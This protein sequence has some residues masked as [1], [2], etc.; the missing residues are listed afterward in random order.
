MTITSDPRTAQV[1][2]L[3]PAFVRETGFHNWNR[4]A[5]VNYEFV[6]IHM[7]DEAGREAGYA[8]A[9][10]MGNLQW[11]Y[12]HNMLRAWLGDAGVIR[13]IGL[14]YR[15]ANVKGQT[16]SACG[17]VAATHDAATERVLDLEVWIENQDG[18]TMAPGTATVVV[19]R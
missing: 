7:D 2:D 1:G 18:G 4:Y 14:Q 17:R 3:L 11:A 16:L 19:R 6:P 13:K 9:F 5:A 8:S 15:S 10:G 12:L